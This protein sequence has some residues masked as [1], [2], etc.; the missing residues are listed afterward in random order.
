MAASDRAIKLSSQLCAGATK[1]P[2]G[3]SSSPVQ[4]CNGI[5]G[6]RHLDIYVT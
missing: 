4:L 2:H 3:C 5:I 1:L 6:H